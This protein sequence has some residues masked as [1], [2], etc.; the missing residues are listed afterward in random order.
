MDKQDEI[1]EKMSQQ[2]VIDVLMTSQQIYQTG[3]NVF[4]PY[5]SHYNIIERNN[6]PMVPTFKK[7]DEAL[8]R[9]YG[10]ESILRGFTEYADS[11]SP[12]FSRTI[13]YYAGLLSFDLHITCRN[14]QPKDYATDEYQKDLERVYKFLDKFQYKQ[15]FSAALKE[16]IRTGAYYGWFRTS[17]SSVDTMETDDDKIINKS[18]YTLQQMPFDYCLITGQDENTYLYDFDMNYFLRPGVSINSFDPIFKQYWKE[19]FGENRDPLLNYNPNAPLN[20]R[21]GTYAQWHQTSPEAGAICLVW[22]YSNARAVSPFAP[23]LKNVLTDDEME[24]L[25]TDANMLAARAILFGSIGMMTKQK[26]G[27]TQNAFKIQPKNM[28]K[29]LAL[30]K[31]G[32]DNNISVAAMPTEETKLGQFDNSDTKD[33]YSTQLSTTAG[34]GASA[35]RIIYSSDKT[36]QFELQCQIEADYNRVSKLYSQFNN[37]L[38]LYVNKRTRKFKFNFNFSGCTYQFMRDKENKNLLDLANVGFVLNESAYAKIVGMQPNEFNRA[39]AEGHNGQMLNNLSQLI[40]IHNSAM[41]KENGR[42]TV[43]VEDRADST[44]LNVDS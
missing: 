20:N 26:S 35:S 6:N 43:A 7:V 34:V 18:T 21:N 24:G 33:I 40:S 32:L 5:T 12:L 11:Y 44:A 3:L 23:L 29:L 42:P 39:L 2:E 14:A 15:H 31:A 9:V 16:I 13:D 27:E 37:I 41:Q 30:V 10:N 38:N 17:A 22:D 4:S 8:K 19:I 1:I 36:S 25:Q 28:T